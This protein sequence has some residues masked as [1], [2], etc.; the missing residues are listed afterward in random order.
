VCDIVP[1]SVL[2]RA[3]S[4]Y[5]SIQDPAYVASLQLQAKEAL[6]DSNNAVFDLVNRAWLQNAAEQDPTRISHT[7]RAT[8]DQV[9][10]FYHFFDLYRPQLALS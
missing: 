2:R 10:E 3:K 5:P 7:T 8:L 6:I 4:G 9:V 1:E